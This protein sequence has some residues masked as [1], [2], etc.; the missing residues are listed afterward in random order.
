MKAFIC[1]CHD[2]CHALGLLR[3]SHL[4]GKAPGASTSYKHL[5]LLAQIKELYDSAPHMLAHDC[6]IFSIPFDNRRLQSTRTLRTYYTFAK[7]IVEK[8]IKEAQDFGTTFRR[9]NDYFHPAPPPD[10]PI[11]IFEIIL[12]NSCCI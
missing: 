2:F 10:I 7:P 8:S 9:I 12:G 3:N 4:H 11:E 1:N 6:D 5:H